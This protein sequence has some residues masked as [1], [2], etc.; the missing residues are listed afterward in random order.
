M[1][2][3]T[4]KKKKKNGTLRFNLTLY[5]PYFRKDEF[6]KSDSGQTTG[7]QIKKIML[8]TYPVIRIDKYTV[9]RCFLRRFLIEIG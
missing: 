9:S 3:K 6:E 1:F 5:I 2:D 4:N 8:I 7:I